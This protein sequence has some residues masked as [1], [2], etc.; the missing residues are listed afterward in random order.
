MDVDFSTRYRF[1][2]LVAFTTSLRKKASLEA[3][4]LPSRTWDLT[5]PARI[6]TKADW[7]RRRMS[8]EAWPLPTRS[9]AG[10]N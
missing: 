4:A 1:D 9:L 6:I 10:Y 8:L 2:N 5:L 7:T 3:R